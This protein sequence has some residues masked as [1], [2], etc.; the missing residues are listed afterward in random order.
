MKHPNAKAAKKGIPRP[1]VV[2][3]HSDTNATKLATLDA[4][5]AVYGPYVQMCVDAL[6]ARRTVNVNMMSTDAIRDAFPVSVMTSHLQRYARDQAIGIVRSWANGIYG[7]TL[8]KYIADLPSPNTRK[9]GPRGPTPVT[10][11]ERL[12]LYT[13]GKHMIREG[14][15]F[16]KHPIEQ[17][18]VDLYW[19]WVWDEAVTGKR[20]VFKRTSMMLGQECA[21]HGPAKAKDGLSGWWISVSTLKSGR[22]TVIPLAPH[23]ALTTATALAKTV[24]LNKRSDGRWTFQFTEYVAPIAALPDDA[25]RVGVDVGKRVLLATSTDRR[26]GEMFS[27]RFDRL[28][29]AVK[30]KRANRQRQGF[31]EDSTRLRLMEQRISGMNKT[32]V[33][34]AVNQCIADHPGAL[35]VLEDLHLNSTKGSKRFAYTEAKRSFA[36]KVVPMFVNPAYTSQECPSCHYVSRRNRNGGKFHCRGCGRISHADCVGGRNLV[37]RS[38]DQQITTDTSVDQVRAILRTRYVALRNRVSTDSAGGRALRRTTVV[39]DAHY[40]AR[41]KK[42]AGH[43]VKQAVG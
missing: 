14:G 27:P 5:L 40:P 3:A 23:P 18:M 28:F 9:T 10:A 17:R 43:S 38:D 8:R 25:P 21:V 34:R 7:R 37:G 39:P 31:R 33:G 32:A 15:S 1:R 11:A 4:L 12:Q 29:V 6:L 24:I 20:P 36:R 22:R 19:S 42:A 2:L 41:P 35:F 13:I 16:G 26:Y 30:T